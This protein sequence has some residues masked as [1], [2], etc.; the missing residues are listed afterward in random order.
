[1][2]TDYYQNK[3]LSNNFSTKPSYASSENKKSMKN[4]DNNISYSQS[5]ENENL[6]SN[7]NE[8][9]GIIFGEGGYRN[10]DI[11]RNYNKNNNIP[12][13]NYNN[14]LNQNNFSQFNPIYKNLNN[15][16]RYNRGFSAQMNYQPRKT[17]TSFNNGKLNNSYYNITNNKRAFS[18]ERN[19]RSNNSFNLNNGYRYN[20]NDIYTFNNQKYIPMNRNNILQSNYAPS[21]SNTKVV[22]IKRAPHDEITNNTRKNLYNNYNTFK[23]EKFRSVNEYFSNPLLNQTTPN[24]PTKNFIKDVKRLPSKKIGDALFENNP[25]YNKINN[26]MNNFGPSNSNQIIDINKNNDINR[27]FELPGGNNTIGY[28]PLKRPY[29]TN[30]YNTQNYQRINSDSQPSLSTQ[31]S[32]PIIPNPYAMDTVED[33]EINRDDNDD[34]RFHNLS[35]TMNYLNRTAPINKM[36]GQPINFA[37]ALQSSHNKLKNP[38]IGRRTIV[39]KLPPLYS[40][41]NMNNINNPLYSKLPIMNNQMDNHIKKPIMTP[42]KNNIKPTISRTSTFN[43]NAKIKV[44]MIDS[45]GN[46]IQNKRDIENNSPP[47][48]INSENI[49]SNYIGPNSSLNSRFNQQTSNQ[50]MNAENMNRNYIP[51]N[52]ASNTLINRNKQF[53]Q[54]QRGNTY[55]NDRVNFNQI[56]NQKQMISEQNN[57]INGQNLNENMDEESISI[58][59]IMPQHCSPDPLVTSQINQMNNMQSNGISTPKEEND[60][61]QS[62]NNENDDENKNKVNISYNDFDC[63]GWIKNYGG[64]SRPGKDVEGNQKINQDSLVSITNI[65][66]VKDFNIFGVLDGHGPDGQKISEFASQFI[67]SQIINHPKIKCLSDPERIYEQLK[68]NDCQIITGAYALCDEQLKNLEFDSY[69]S[70]STCILIIH[71]GTHIVCANVGDSRGIVTYDDEDDGDP[72]LDYLEAAQLS[73]D[74]KPEIEEERNRILMSGG[75]VEQMKN[76]YGQGIGP[77][78]V[79]VRGANYPGLAMSRSIGDFKGKSIGVI[80][81]PGLLEYNLTETTKFFVICSDGVWKYLNNETVKN[82]GKSFYL[83]NNASGFCHQIVDHAVSEWERN[84]GMVDD[85]TVVVAFF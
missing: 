1:M 74:Y 72:E 76:E 67:P 73:I 59:Q 43:D 85:V 30:N 18:G 35:S 70:G 12:Q 13:N 38:D 57:I 81:E 36:E 39:K 48:A 47:P 66:N 33:N 32:S 11:S 49:P 9:N 34:D 44:Q 75:V 21:N 2:K 65:N 62:Q 29:S 28:F 82:L 69:N 40:N 26:N 45:R 37:Q 22:K 61:L 20:S 46:P 83:N 25:N 4:L 56:F 27:D 31:I 6:N 71:I 41:N 23:D 50:M 14:N 77:Y 79:W 80:S 84:D 54:N 52:Q 58:S 78:R 3:S 63:S 19:Y 53:Y 5:D 51:Q 42:I 17:F 55:I 68:E 64:V 8:N 10:N 16:I 60:G 15:N 24:I 7:E